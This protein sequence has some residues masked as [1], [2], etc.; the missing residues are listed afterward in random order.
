M[1]QNLAKLIKNTENK[2]LRPLFDV[3]C[4]RFTGVHMPSHDHIHHLRVWNY[5][6]E[7]VLYL[8]GNGV[9]VSETDLEQ[10]IVAVFFHDQGMSQTPSAE[11]GKISRGLCKQFFKDQNLELLRGFD[12]VLQAIE[13]HDKKNYVVPENV[14]LVQQFDDE[15]RLLKM[16]NIAD[17]LDAFGRVGT[18]RYMEIYLM[19]GTELTELSE[20]VVSNLQTRFAFFTSLVGS[21]G[22][23][24][25]HHHLRFMETRNYFKDLALHLK[26]TNYNSSFLL[27]PIGVFNYIQNEVLILKHR[28]EELCTKV[29]SAEPDFYC[30][31]F[32][33]KLTMELRA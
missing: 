29:L 19:R 24:Y 13:D 5:A 31:H 14:P 23:L 28:P 26:V 21:K 7:L 12:T 17:D 25:K 15:S 20:K 18:Y 16:L 11:H 3:C 2:W 1:P 22:V 6:K 4:T 32:F 27:G 9:A 30:R 33:E 8:H 10:L